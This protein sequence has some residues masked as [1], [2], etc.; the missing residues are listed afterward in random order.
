MDKSLSQDLNKMQN[1][2][3]GFYRTKKFKMQ[4]VICILLAL[5]ILTGAFLGVYLSRSFNGKVIF[6]CRVIG[7]YNH[8]YDFNPSFLHELN[9]TDEEFENKA[10]V[11]V[12]QGTSTVWYDSLVALGISGVDYDAAL[13]MKV[14]QCYILLVD[15]KGNIVYQGTSASELLVALKDMRF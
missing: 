7:A 15:K 11:K 12:I 4:V 5:I 13:E 10:S 8:F 1:G 3:G 6:L 9:M 2:I 14:S